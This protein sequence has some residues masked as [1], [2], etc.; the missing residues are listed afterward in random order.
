[1]LHHTQRAAQHNLRHA[2]RL[3][4][5]NHRT[6]QHKRHGKGTDA[7]QPAPGRRLWV[8]ARHK[9]QRRAGALGVAGKAARNLVH[10]QVGQ[11]ADGRGGQANAPQPRRV[12]PAQRA[13]Q[14]SAQARAAAAAK[15]G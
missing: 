10:Q 2:Q 6:P 12:A 8:G 4:P 1:M 15:L 7:Q 5:G 9:A 3:K 11:A 14:I 13:N